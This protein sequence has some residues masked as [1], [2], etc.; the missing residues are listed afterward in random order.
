MDDDG[1]NNNED[2][3]SPLYSCANLCKTVIKQS[4]T[5]TAYNVLFMYVTYNIV[6]FIKEV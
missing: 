2:G 1:C 4:H 5:E 6:Y 3:P